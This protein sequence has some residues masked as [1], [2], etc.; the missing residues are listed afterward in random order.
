[1]T[2]PVADRR[3]S[4]A[5]PSRPRHWL[6]ALVAA[7]AAGRVDGGPVGRRRRR[8]RVV[9]TTTILADL[10][11]QVGGDRVTRGEP[12]AQGR[13]GA[14]LRSHA[15][16]RP[17]RRR[18]GPRRSSTGW[19]WTTGWRTSSTTP[20]TDAPVVRLAEDLEGVDLPQGR[21]AERRGRQPAPLAQRGLCREVRGADRARRW[22]PRIPTTPRTT[23]RAG[24]RT[25]RC[26]RT[27]TRRP[28]RRSA[29]SPR[30]TARSSRFHDAF[31][32][33]AAAY[34]LTIDGTIV[35][36]PGP[37]PERRRRSSDL[38][39]GHQGQGD[40]GD[41]RRGPVQRRPGPD[42]RGRDGR[43]RRLGPLHGLAWATRRRT[44]T[45]G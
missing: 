37:G 42:D 5:T 41:L 35:D 6:A 13:R 44:P 9:T 15:V 28:A 38:D 30:R 31:P 34:G 22:S 7:A 45:P 16:R 25:R 39:H 23:R 26:S 32:Y 21:R 29:P 11:R 3:P 36:A 20:G 4:L 14:H 1:M 8:C 27:S 24:A 18:G 33:F 12:R 40:Q 19:A 17:P 2:R 10:V 43:H